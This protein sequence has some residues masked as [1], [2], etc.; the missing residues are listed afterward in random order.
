[1]HKLD[2]YGEKEANCVKRHDF[3]IVNHLKGQKLK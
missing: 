3:V 1:M 2:E